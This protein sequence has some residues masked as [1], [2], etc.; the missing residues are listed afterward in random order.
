MGFNIAHMGYTVTQPHSFVSVVTQIYD[1]THI[2][3]GEDV[4]SILSLGKL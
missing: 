4:A 1:S 3:F 2:F